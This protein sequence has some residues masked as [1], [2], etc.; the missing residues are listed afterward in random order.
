MSITLFH[1][2]LMINE[3]YNLFTVCSFQG[4][5]KQ[6]PQVDWNHLWSPLCKN[7]VMLL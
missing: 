3:L 6:E 7:Q 5:S 4:P 1:N 2:E